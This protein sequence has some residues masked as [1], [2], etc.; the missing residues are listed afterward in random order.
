MIKAEDPYGYK[1]FTAGVLVFQ[2]ETVGAEIRFRRA[3]AIVTD[4]DKTEPQ[5]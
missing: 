5:S 3:E 4:S 1:G 2:S